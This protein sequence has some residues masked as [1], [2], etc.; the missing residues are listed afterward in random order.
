MLWEL[1]EVRSIEG[2]YTESDTGW[3]LN[4]CEFHFLPPTK[5][6]ISSSV[7]WKPG[8]VL[9]PNKEP[10]TTK[11]ADGHSPLRGRICAFCPSISSSYSAWSVAHSR[12]STNVC[13]LNEW[14]NGRRNEWIYSSGMINDLRWI[15]KSCQSNQIIYNMWNISKNLWS[16]HLWHIQ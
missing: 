7:A 1:N 10:V 16:L 14:I 12:D 2:P 11:S 13:W 6:S 8:L 4:K 15:T 9:V 3:I 5:E